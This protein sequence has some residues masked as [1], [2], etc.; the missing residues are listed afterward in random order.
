MTNLQM[1]RKLYR[2]K[3]HILYDIFNG[4]TE[5]DKIFTALSIYNKW[6]KSLS[7]E[8]LQHKIKIYNLEEK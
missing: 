7:T 6:L 1:R 8:Q 4:I 5:E 2:R 3:A